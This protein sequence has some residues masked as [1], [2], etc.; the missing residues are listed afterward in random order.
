MGMNCVF[1]DL[2]DFSLLL[3]Y[4][5]WC[6]TVLLLS[7]LFHTNTSTLAGASC[8][9]HRAEFPVFPRS[10]WLRRLQRSTSCTNTW[11]CP[12]SSTSVFL[13]PSSS[14]WLRCRRRTARLRCRPTHLSAPGIR[15]LGG[16]LAEYGQLC[17]SHFR[18]AQDL[19]W[20][21]TTLLWKLTLGNLN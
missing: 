14:G 8:V 2:H 12:R 6:E 15:S 19:G 7:P 18:N 10:S 16:C 1:R 3:L 4:L 21:F 11:R 13:A 17:P 20:T 9:R 5:L